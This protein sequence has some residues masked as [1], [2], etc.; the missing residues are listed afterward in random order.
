MSKSDKMYAKSPKIEKDDKGK[1]GIKKP[2]KADAEDMG[3]EGNDVEGAGDGMPVDIHEKE[4][5]SMHKRHQEEQKAMHD[6]HEKD[7]KDM[8]ARHHEVAESEKGNE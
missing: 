3:T 1:P 6:R 4:R 5:V 8:H 2:S 7:L